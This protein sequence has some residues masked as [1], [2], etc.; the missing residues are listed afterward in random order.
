MQHRPPVPPYRPVPPLAQDTADLTEQPVPLPVRHGQ[1]PGERAEQ[2]DVLLGAVDLLP[3]VL[4]DAGH[5]E[6]SAG[7]DPGP[8]VFEFARPRPLRPRRQPLADLLVH[9][10]YFA[11]ERITVLGEH[12]LLGPDGQVTARPQGLPGPPVADRRV[13][14]VPGRGRVDQADPLI[15]DPVLEPAHEH[16]DRP[17]GQVGAGHHGQFGPQLHAGDAEATPGQRAGGLARGAAHLEQPV[18][19]PQAGQADQVVVQGLGI[20]RPHL[21]VDLR[22]LVDSQPQP[23]TLVI[24]PAPGPVCHP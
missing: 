19:G 14:P 20:I 13:D 21:I 11:E 22:R 17:A 15:A 10:L 16:L 6:Q 12:M 9:V 3:V 2:P 1:V 4:A 7:L 18:A 5:L 23:L 8:V 24:G